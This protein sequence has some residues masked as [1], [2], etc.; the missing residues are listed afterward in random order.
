MSHSPK[1]TFA[2]NDFCIKKIGS[3]GN[4]SIHDP[5]SN[6]GFNFSVIGLNLVECGPETNSVRG[7][8]LSAGDIDE[9]TIHTEG[10]VLRL[11]GEDILRTH[12]EKAPIKQGVRGRV[13]IVLKKREN[14]SQSTPR[15][16]RSNAELDRTTARL[17]RNKLLELG[18]EE[19]A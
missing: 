13:L 5:Q 17:T 8:T 19:A 14:T 6:P 7:M 11:S 15:I 12:D 2:G 18:L 10:K 9:L 3:S 1:N 16:G 4:I